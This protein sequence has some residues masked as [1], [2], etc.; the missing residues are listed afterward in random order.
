MKIIKF[1]YDKQDGSKPKERILLSLLEP[2]TD[3]A[4]YDLGEL[5]EEELN[6]LQRQINYI[7]EQ[8]SEIVEDYDLSKAYRRFKPDK[9]TFLDY[10]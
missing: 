9:M 10:P 3:Y 2:F 4:G 5:T 7:Q 8:I 6:A 1:S